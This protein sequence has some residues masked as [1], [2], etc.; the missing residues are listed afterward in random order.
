MRIKK[1]NPGHVKTRLYGEVEK[2][3]RAGAS[4]IIFSL[5]GEGV[6][7]KKLVAMHVMG[8]RVLF[9]DPELN[10]EMSY[11]VECGVVGQLTGDC[12][13]LRYEGRGLHSLPTA[14]LK[15]LFL[16]GKAFALVPLSHRL[17]LAV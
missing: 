9:F 1:T 14:Y 12:A 10:P 16:D 13:E 5:P 17:A 3:L 15:R 11:A 7:R 6:R 2:A 8:D 4:E